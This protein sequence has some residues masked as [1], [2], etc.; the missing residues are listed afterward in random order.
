MGANS[1]NNYLQTS[2]YEIYEKNILK[3]VRDEICK[4]QYLYRINQENYVLF[5][6][7]IFDTLISRNI[8]KPS[9]VFLIMK[10]K[11][12]NMDFPLNLVKKF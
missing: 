7:D 8:A 3:M 10:Q 1:R 4:N 6:F 11:M 5:S 9:A 2:T 12:R